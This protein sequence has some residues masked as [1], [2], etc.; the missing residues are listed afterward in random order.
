M[1]YKN[2]QNGQ[3]KKKTK[4]KNNILVYLAKCMTKNINIKI[5]SLV[6]KMKI[7]ITFTKKKTLL[8]TTKTSIKKCFLNT[9]GALLVSYLPKKK[10]I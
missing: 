10:T 2:G 6:H 8:V 7:F 3:F 4:E 9:R 1:W 5:I